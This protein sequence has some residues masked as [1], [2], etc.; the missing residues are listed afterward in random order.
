MASQP[1]TLSEARRRILRRD[2]P[3][4]PGTALHNGR[5]GSQYGN[6][7][8]I[9]A[10]SSSAVSR[11]G[12]AISAGRHTRP[13]T[14]PS[15]ATTANRGSSAQVAARPGIS[16]PPDGARSLAYPE[17]RYEKEG[18][19]FVLPAFP[20]NRRSDPKRQSELRVYS[21]IAKNPIPGPRD[22]RGEGASLGSG[23]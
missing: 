10:G 15:S 7:I 11:P 19:M 8:G 22:L 23:D 1:Q 20:E 17:S 3:A 18:H 9:W 12:T 4:D 5:S 16:D 2:G 21:E 14:P 6:V 13:L